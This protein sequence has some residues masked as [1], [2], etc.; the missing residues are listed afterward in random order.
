LSAETESPNPPATDPS[1]WA[2]YMPAPVRVAVGVA[3][4]VAAGVSMIGNA[5]PAPVW[6]ALLNLA[7]TPFG[8]AAAVALVLGSV[9]FFASN[10]ASKLERKYEARVATVEAHVERARE[11]HEQCEKRVLRAVGA[12]VKLVQGDTKG[13]QEMLDS[14]MPADPA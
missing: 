4:G 3:A 12:C 9:A 14:I 8:A 7:A 10:A 5:V 13:A 6:P 1:V 11:A 2:K